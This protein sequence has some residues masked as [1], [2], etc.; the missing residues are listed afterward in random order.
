MSNPKSKNITWSAGVVSYQDRILR[1]DHKGAILWFTGLSASGKSTLSRLVEKE[2]FVRGC[3]TYILDGDNIR[4]GLNS[5][6]AFTPEERVENI[7]RIGEVAKLMMDAGV[8][9][10]T[11]FISPYRADRRR[12]RQI[13]PPGSFIE[14]FCQCSLLEC[15]SLDPK[16][17]YKRARI[18]K[19]PEFTGISAPYE[20]P[21][22]PE[23]IVDTEHHT[24]EECVQK[25]VEYL[26]KNRILKLNGAVSAQ[27]LDSMTQK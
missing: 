26:E 23:I 5:D 17:L 2:L 20:E 8:I 21:E 11:A 15:E 27:N 14:I 13:V 6:L 4:H 1:N 19:I 12:C 22:T 24:P 9:S 7:R 3:N 10:L 18:G 25:I 16:G